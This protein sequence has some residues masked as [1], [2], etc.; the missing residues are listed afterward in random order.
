MPWALTAA[1]KFTHDI[2]AVKDGKKRELEIGGYTLESPECAEA[3]LTLAR[4]RSSLAE[5]QKLV[6]RIAADI[7]YVDGSDQMCI[8]RYSVW[9]E[10]RDSG[11]S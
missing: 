2:D 10:L 9:P 5:T 4:R 3:R 8:I 7:L 1:A 11:S 6:D